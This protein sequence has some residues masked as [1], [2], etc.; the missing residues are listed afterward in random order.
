MKNIIHFRAD[1]DTIIHIDGQMA[2]ICNKENCV[3]IIPQK[4]KMYV[5]FSTPNMLSQAMCFYDLCNTP[6]C[7]NEYIECIPY[8]NRHYDCYYHP[9]R[10][11]DRCMEKILYS[12]IIG[13][14]FISVI[15]KDKN[16]VST[17]S[18]FDN[19]HPKFSYDIAPYDDIECSLFGKTLVCISKKDNKYHFMCIDTNDYTIKQNYICDHINVQKNIIR[20]L[21][22][23][24]DLVGQ[25]IVC[26][27]DTTSNMECES[28]PIY[29]N[30]KAYDVTDNQLVPYALLMCIKADNIK[31]AKSLLAP[32]IANA[33]DDKLKEYFGKIQ[34]IFPD[35]YTQNKNHFYYTIKNE[36]YQKYDFT[37]E[38]N[39]ILDIN[40]IV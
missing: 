4:D 30:K 23:L 8:M 32:Q 36:K 6:C 31:H 7:D 28:Y 27:Y 38:N 11:R 9:I 14:L 19:N 1:Y 37:V 29:R 21:Q 35:P 24:D 33:S 20:T 16:C 34:S 26:N 10:Y 25:G 2:G 17:L 5:T 40:E 22:Y 39:K 13:K 12:I 3:D 18:I 15:G